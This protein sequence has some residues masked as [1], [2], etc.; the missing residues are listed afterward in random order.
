[1]PYSN[2]YKKSKIR[3]SETLID[4]SFSLDLVLDFFLKLSL[5]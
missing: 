3:P 1:M 4:F 5:P 2:K